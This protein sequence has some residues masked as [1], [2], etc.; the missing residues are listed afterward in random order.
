MQQ[1]L[2]IECVF[3]CRTSY[4]NKEGK[5]PII[6]RISLRENR[7]D[8]FT[9]VYSKKSSWDK[10]AQR[11]KSNAEGAAAL[12]QKL[13]RLLFECNEHFNA[14]KYSGKVF[15]LNDLI[16]RIKGKEELPPTIIAYLA[17]KAKELRLRVGVDI[18]RSTLQKYL[19][20]AKHLE[21]FLQ[22]KY[23][24]NDL[25]ISAITE[26]IITDYFYYLRVVKANSHNTC[27]VN[28]QQR[29]D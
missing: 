10:N 29:V 15:F 14:L 6:L 2:E 11:I 21:E 1:F 18:T 28:R 20:C 13:E 27:V 25:N 17:Y 4:Q 8:L 9:G 24:H 22:S 5:H 26:T 3:H 7:K 19:R 16:L 12:N 23:K